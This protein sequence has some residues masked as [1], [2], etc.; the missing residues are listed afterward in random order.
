METNVPWLLTILFCLRVPSARAEADL[1][2]TWRLEFHTVTGAKIPVLGTTRTQNHT[3]SH[4][5]IW[6][7][8][9]SLWGEHRACSVQVETG[10]KMTHTTLSPAFVRAIPQSR[11]PIQV[12]DDGEVRWVA[13]DFPGTVLGFDPKLTGGA[14]PKDEDAPGVE[15]S[16]LD[17]RPGVTVHVRAP[18]FGEVEIY[19][20]QLTA[21]SVRGQERKPGLIEGGFV[22][23]HFRHRS[24]GASHFLFGVNPRIQPIEGASTFRM[25]KVEDDTTCAQLTA[26]EGGEGPWVF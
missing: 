12:V 21:S 11:Y 10:M 2:G 23:T 15:D 3:L 16:D 25:V 24:I 1:I 17:G 6:P 26:G 9:G 5:R 14:V 13:M 4:M 20:A 8:G 18:F 19:I 22:F 7:E